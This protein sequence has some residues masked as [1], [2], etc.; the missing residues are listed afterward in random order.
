MYFLTGIIE[1]FNFTILSGKGS[2]LEER[3]LLLSNPDISISLH[4]RQIDPPQK[5]VISIIKGKAAWS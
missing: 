3:K 2:W 5:P 4:Y 1:R